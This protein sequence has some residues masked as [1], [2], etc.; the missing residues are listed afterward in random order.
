MFLR[1]QKLYSSLRHPLVGRSHTAFNASVSVC[2][3]V[4]VSS[5]ECC[6]RNHRKRW[7]GQ[8][9]GS[10]CGT[11]A[12]MEP[13]TSL[14]GFLS[15]AQ[16]PVSAY[17]S[18]SRCQFTSLYDNWGDYDVWMWGRRVE[19]SSDEWRLFVLYCEKQTNIKS[20]SIKTEMI[21][22]ILSRQ[23]VLMRFFDSGKK[24]ALESQWLNHL[25][26]PWR[27]FCSVFSSHGGLIWRANV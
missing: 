21:G 12:H 19:L 1:A 20:Q 15:P 13:I 26:V 6:R 27:P 23:F 8:I 10:K 2:A 16:C 3:C 25:S 5:V 11:Q 4:C 18:L 17:L 9:W 7:K 24:V 22:C 14:T